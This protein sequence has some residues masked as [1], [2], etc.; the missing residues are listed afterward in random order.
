MAAPGPEFRWGI[1]LRRSKLNANGTEESTNRQEYEIAHY[2]RDNNMGV[3]VQ[4][5]KDISSAWKPGAP[6]PSYKNA[7]VDLALGTIDG[8]AVLSIDRL[9]RRKD[10]VRP[11]LDAL[12]AMGGR[13][14]SLEDELDTADDRPGGNTELRLRELVARAE[15]ES[16]RTSQRAKLMA[17]H[18]ARKGLHQ[19]S[20]NRPFGRTI[21]WFGLVPQEVELIHEAARR[22]VE[23]ESIH[24]ICRDWTSRGVSTTTGVTRWSN[25]KLKVKSHFV[26]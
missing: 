20:S 8:I 22:V 12:E 5:Y 14:L 19:T 26:V 17:K 7:L 4:T 23:G 1:V 15:G 21:D 25:D 24:A 16:A 18:R 10:Q 11:V 13:L 3:I 9:T 6:R 2:I